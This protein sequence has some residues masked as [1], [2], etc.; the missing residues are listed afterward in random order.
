MVIGLVTVKSYPSSS[1][2]L[3]VVVLTVSM[4]LRRP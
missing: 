1:M 2:V 3:M 4:V